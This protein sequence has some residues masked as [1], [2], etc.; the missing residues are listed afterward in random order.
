MVGSAHQGQLVDVGAVG[1]RP[2]LDVVD[3]A[4]VARYI[5]ARAGA[6]GV[7]G[8]SVRVRILV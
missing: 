6:A 8:V 1:G 2:V 7:L 4:P 3:L 5:A